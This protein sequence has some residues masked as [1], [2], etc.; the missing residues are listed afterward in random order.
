MSRN[1]ISAS[2]LIFK[3][4]SYFKGLYIYSGCY[5]AYI[6]V[7]VLYFW[8]AYKRFD[9]SSVLNKQLLFYLLLLI[10]LIAPIPFFVYYGNKK[11][12]ENPPIQPNWRKY[13]GIIRD[14]YGGL[15][16]GG[17]GITV[18]VDGEKHH[19][20]QEVGIDPYLAFAYMREDNVI[21]VMVN[22][23]NKYE[24][25]VL[26]DEYIQRQI[27]RNLPRIQVSDQSYKYNDIH[28]IGENQKIIV[29]ILDRK[30]TTYYWDTGFHYGIHV[31]LMKA[32]IS[33]TEDMTGKQY[34]F[35]CTVLL[36]RGILF[37]YEKKKTI[38]IPVEVIVDK[39]DYSKY[40]VLL[41]KALEEKLGLDRDL[42]M[43]K[44]S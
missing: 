44:L 6:A 31:N 18:D 26:L 24:C 42:L 35:N 21:D 33:Y 3:E 13:R 28:E 15:G 1:Y 5:I 25:K 22:L 4:R 20:T 17:Y 43:R 39:D 36:P 27:A 41:D 12:W 23:N 7:G 19:Y 38:E 29:G 8:Y 16:I 10:V 32:V 34:F 30:S 40:T 14:M 2:N 37:N 11:Y 9:T